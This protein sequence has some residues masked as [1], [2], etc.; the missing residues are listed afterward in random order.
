MAEKLLEKDASYLMMI[1]QKQG[2]PLRNYFM[3]RFHKAML[4]VPS[5]EKRMAIEVV[6]QGDLY[7]SPF[8]LSISK[9]K[10]D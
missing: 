7:N 9:A 10:I 4:E 2:E 3:L 8:H 6:K 5:V 1:K